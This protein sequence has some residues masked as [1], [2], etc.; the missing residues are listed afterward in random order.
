M[1]DKAGGTCADGQEEQ[2]SPGSDD[3]AEHLARTLTGRNE[4]PRCVV[5]VTPWGSRSP[6]V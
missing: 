6:D 4:V 3:I 5:R 1:H 2:D